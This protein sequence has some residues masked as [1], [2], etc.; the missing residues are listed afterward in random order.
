[1]K[2]SHATGS[3]VTF[4]QEGMTH[5]IDFE[6]EPDRKLAAISVAQCH[7]LEI[8]NRGPDKKR[9]VMSLSHFMVPH[10][11]QKRVLDKSIGIIIDN[12]IAH[13]GVLE[14]AEFRI[15]GGVAGENL[16][17]RDELKTSILE[18]VPGAKIDE[19]VGHEN[20]RNPRDRGGESTDYLFG[21]DGVTYRKMTLEAIFTGDQSLDAVSK[22]LRNENG[23]FDETK[24]TNHQNFLDGCFEQVRDRIELQT[25]IV[26]NNLQ[27]GEDVFA[28]I[29]EENI[30]EARAQ[31]KVAVIV[32]IIESAVEPM[33]I[34]V[35]DKDGLIMDRE[36]IHSSTADLPSNKI[37]TPVTEELKENGRY[38]YID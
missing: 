5:T 35:C 36:N 29:T 7:I 24:V 14:A 13:Q 19:P 33:L 26:E 1:M 34:K 28:K 4:V 32:R 30:K 8:S 6:Q 11:R 2:G 27:R 10:L 3:H 9:T 20:K 22:N 17:L 18:R 31:G 12:F 15:Y 25:R 37:T 23:K 38:L 21:C 16:E